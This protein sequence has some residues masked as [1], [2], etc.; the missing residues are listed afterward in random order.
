MSVTAVPIRP[1]SR[2][3]LGMLWGGLGVAALGALGLAWAGTGRAIAETGSPAQFMAYN[4]GQPGVVT[5]GTGLQY[6]VLKEGQ[7]DNPTADDVVLVKYKGT[8]RDGTV[9]DQNERAPME[10]GQVIPGF[11]EGLKLMRRGGEYRL[12]IK[13][14]LGYGDRETGGVI[15]PNSVLI[16]DVTLI[17]FIPAAMLRQMQQQQQGMGL[18]GG[19]PPGGR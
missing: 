5:T 17:D 13:P 16:F 6:R 10:V 12:W 19:M 1:T 9:F 4:A 18:P 11:S 7:G 3:V 15:P 8:L 2:R 14:E